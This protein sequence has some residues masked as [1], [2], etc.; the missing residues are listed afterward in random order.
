MRMMIC[1]SG[2]GRRSRAGDWL[3]WVIFLIYKSHHKLFLKEETATVATGTQAGRHIVD[4]PTSKQKDDEFICIP[5]GAMIE[6]WKFNLE[7]KEENR[8][9]IKCTRLVILISNYSELSI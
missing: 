6:K 1:L 4:R 5:V 2:G 9:L 7:G 8:K 3:S